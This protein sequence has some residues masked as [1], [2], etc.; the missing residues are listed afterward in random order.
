M[1]IWQLLRDLVAKQHSGRTLGIQADLKAEE[2]ALDAVGP[3][4]ER[5]F[6]GLRR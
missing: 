5:R 1:E 3:A 4:R 2:I 6:G